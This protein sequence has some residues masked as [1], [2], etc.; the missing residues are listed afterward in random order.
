MYEKVYIVKPNTSNAMS[1]DKYIVC[2]H[3]I[4]NHDLYASNYD[5]LMRKKNNRLYSLVDNKMPLNFINKMNDI[6]VILGQRQL[7]YFDQALTI[8][9]SPNK[10]EAINGVV[11]KNMQK[12]TVMCEKLGLPYVKT[13]VFLEKR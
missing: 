10:Y 5:I 4:P 7:E 11:S 9:S 8:M 6:N 13:N 3:K 1:H 2:L 12:C